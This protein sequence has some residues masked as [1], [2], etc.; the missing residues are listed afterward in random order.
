MQ[1]FW[2]QL[3]NITPV[4]VLIVLGWISGKYLEIK[5][6]SP[7]SKLLLYVFTPI[8]VF[9]AINK[10]PLDV[11]F[12]VIPIFFFGVC[13][14]ICIG[15]FLLLSKLW[16]RQKQTTHIL[17]YSSGSGNIAFYGVPIA[18]LLFGESSLAIMS[19]A[20]IG[21]ILYD[22]SVGYVIASGEKIQPHTVFNKLIKFP[23]LIAAAVALLLK[24]LSI[25][26][27]PSLHLYS[28]LLLNSQKTIATLGIMLIGISLANFKFE[29]DLRYLGYLFITKFLVWPLAI[30]LLMKVLSAA[31]IMDFTGIKEILVLIATVPV[32]TNAVI[33]ATTFGVKQEKASMGVF[34]TALAS[35]VMIP[36]WQYLLR[37][38]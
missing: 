37:G 22:S 33:L 35:L 1:L 10:A 14:A 26:I 29:V 19:L 21:F 27:D 36:L 38:M 2:S 15:S 9:D 18:L 28:F 13:S 30:I 24:L 16:P 12:V 5:D 34:V 17:A 20:I 25:H 6:A 8:L 32:A 3:L 23:P 31:D 7:L 11:S 4:F